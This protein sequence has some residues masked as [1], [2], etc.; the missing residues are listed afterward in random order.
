MAIP[1]F[2]NTLLSDLGYSLVIFGSY[3]IAGKFVFNT[4]IQGTIN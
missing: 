3:A 4:K 2:R 1:F